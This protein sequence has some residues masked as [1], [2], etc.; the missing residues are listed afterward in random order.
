MSDTE[1]RPDTADKAE[2]IRAFEDAQEILATLEARA[3]QLDS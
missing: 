1:D 2:L 3:R